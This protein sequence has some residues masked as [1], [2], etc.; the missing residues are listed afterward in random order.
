MSQKA[1]IPFCCAWPLLRMSAGLVG[2]F[3]GKGI[4][5]RG[6]SVSIYCFSGLKVTFGLN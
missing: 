1:F 3:V 6:Y 2:D 5:G 4:G